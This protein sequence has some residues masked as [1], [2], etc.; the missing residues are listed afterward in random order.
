MQDSSPLVTVVV[1]LYNV[2]PSALQCLQSLAMQD[3]DGCYEVVCID[4]GSDDG[5]SELIDSIERRFT[6]F[7][8]YHFQNE[9]L[10]EARNRGV[11]LARADMISFVDGDDYVAPTYIRTLLEA[12]RGVGRRL[13]I[14]NYLRVTSKGGSKHYEQLVS[15]TSSVTLSRTDAQREFLLG[16]IRYSSW[17]CLAERSLYEQTPF[18]HGVFNEDMRAFPSHLGLIDEIIV[19]S[20]PLYAYVERT[21][22]ITN[23]AHMTERHL[24]DRLEAVQHCERQLQTWTL[25]FVDLIPWRV[26]LLYLGLASA[27]SLLSSRRLG[28]KYARIG[29]MYIREHVGIIFRTW[30]LNRLSAFRMCKMVLLA[31]SPSLYRCL[32]RLSH[33]RRNI[34]K[35]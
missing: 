33:S 21:D 18:I 30:Y 22:S 10:S 9:G 1:P 2:M 14:S 13:V 23:P 3:F 34:G 26:A 4:D 29:T 32:A 31:V 7:R 16:R 35:W 6:H 20:E 17:G 27:S 5:T 19:L 8:V 24:R 25:D 11:R 15:G 28:L 12:H